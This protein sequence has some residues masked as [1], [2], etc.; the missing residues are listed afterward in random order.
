VAFDTG[1]ANAPIDS[2]AILATGGRRRFDDGGRLASAGR[3]DEDEVRRMLRHPFFRRPPPKSLDR[4]AFGA[5]LVERVARRRPDLA[6]ADLVATMTEFVARSVA[7]AHRRHLPRRPRVVDVVVSGGG[8]RNPV[9]MR[10]LAELLAPTPVRSTAELGIDPD[11]KEA[12][13]FAVLADASAAASAGNL[14]RVTG[15]RRPVVLG[16]FVP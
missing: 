2:A 6:G 4:D 12:V 8:V 10:R 13:A 5:P 14:P 11:A 16:K 7:D 15:A 9:L 1:P 3:V